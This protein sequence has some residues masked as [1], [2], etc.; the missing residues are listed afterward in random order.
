MKAELDDPAWMFTVRS[1][2]DP[3]LPCISRDLAIAG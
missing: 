2:S 1:G 3:K